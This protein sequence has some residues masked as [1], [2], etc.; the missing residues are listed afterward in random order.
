MKRKMKKRGQATLEYVIVLIAIVGVIIAIVG[1]VIFKKDDSTGIGKL[2][3]EA[4]ET[5]TEHSEKLIDMTGGSD[6]PGG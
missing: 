5:M 4:G 1:V 2:F 6:E 3:Y